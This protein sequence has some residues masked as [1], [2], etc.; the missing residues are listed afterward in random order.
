MSGAGLCAVAPAKVNLSLRVVGRR[1]D[2]YH[3]LDTVF[4]AVGL[5]DRLTVNP[6]RRLSM[7]CDA[8]GIPVDGSNLVLRAA[9]MLRERH[10]APELGGRFEL[11]KEI[12]AGGGLGGGSSDAAATLVLAAEHWGLAVPRGDMLELARELGADVPFFLY[13]GTARGRG[14]GD[15]IEPLE[16]ASERPL[17]LGLPP[18]GISTARVF[19][20]FSARLTPPGNDVSLRDPSAHKVPVGKDFR[21]AVND[22]EEVVF[23]DWPELRRF[24]DALHEAGAEPAMLSGSGSTVFGVFDDEVAM[25][26]AMRRLRAAFEGW[27]VIATRTVRSAVQVVGTSPSGGG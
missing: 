24:R 27:R 26:H 15:R 3:E 5:W 19:A 20:R 2:G 8:P 13:G 7:T 6:D 16:P 23:R 9:S 17:L 10:G 4:Q 21:L 25:H 12:P 18:F 14:R 11:R 22:L 1:E